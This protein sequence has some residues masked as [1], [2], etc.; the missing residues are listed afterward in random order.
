MSHP[1]TLPWLVALTALA[2]L[3][4]AGPQ[5]EGDAA[6]AQ[7]EITD[8]A[9]TW[10][11]QL[12]L[13]SKGR[14]R[15]RELILPADR[16]QG[17]G[18][19]GEPEL[20]PAMPD[21]EVD[22]VLAATG[23]DGF[24]LPL[25]TFLSGD[26]AGD[27]PSEGAGRTSLLLLGEDMQAVFESFALAGDDRPELPAGAVLHWLPRLVL[28]E[29]AP[30][31]GE[32]ARDWPVGWLPAS[33]EAGAG[34]RPLARPDTRALFSFLEREGGLSAV[35]SWNAPLE[36]HRLAD[37]ESRGRLGEPVPAHANP[38]GTLSAVFGLTWRSVLNEIGGRSTPEPPE[39]AA[40]IA[41]LPPRLGLA[42]VRVESLGDEQWQIDLVL[43]NEGVLPTFSSQAERLRAAEGLRLELRG[44][45]V[46]AVATA[47]GAETLTLGAGELRPGPGGDAAS[48]V[49]TLPL[50]IL[51]GGDERRVR[52]VVEAPEGA[53]LDLR[54]LSAWA[55]RVQRAVPL[56]P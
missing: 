47:R 16:T 3:G 54:A 34:P 41:S 26:G 44:G 19:D 27:S 11:D 42:P 45:I 21:A 5:E 35:V 37:P 7:G 50:P 4:A 6:P 55:G 8:Q 24:Q 48:A 22:D 46:V 49:W 9:F 18:S 56:Q 13:G 28:P 39:A 31:L 25:L 17:S 10:I 53:E 30:G 15:V 29:V 14:V 2:S 36:I 52:L 38:R 12:V 40:W 1:K 32:Y 33:L 20:V 23:V 51:G 43:T